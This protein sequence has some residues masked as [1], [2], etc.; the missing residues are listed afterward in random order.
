M[1]RLSNWSEMA[2][3][4]PMTHELMAGI[5]DALGGKAEQVTIT[6]LIEHTYYALIRIRKGDDVIEI[7]A[8]PSDAI[9]LATT[10]T[11]TL[12]IYVEESVL[13]ES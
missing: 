2:L 8:R 13:D 3:G 11:P 9:A 6:Q 4:R 1:I 7:D 10:Y 12:P 5:I